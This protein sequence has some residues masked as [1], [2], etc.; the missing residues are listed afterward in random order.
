MQP[1]LFWRPTESGAIQCE[2]CPQ[3]CLIAAGKSGR[4]GIRTAEDG[5]LLARGYGLVSAA[6]SDPMEKKPLYHFHPGRMIFSVGGWG[7]NLACGF[8]QNWTISQQVDLRSERMPP[9][10]IVRAA[11]REKSIGIAYTY[12]EP[13][14]NLE[15]VHDCA[16]LARKEGLVNVLVTNGFVE[17]KPAAWLLPLIDALN[18]DIKSLDDTF[19][20]KQCR[21]TLEPVL[22][23]SRQA[24]A[25]GC[26]VEI[27]NLLIP[28]LNDTEEQVG[29]VSRW[30]LDNLGKTTPFHLSAYRP[31]YRMTIPATPAAVLERS[32]ARCRQDL[33]YVYVGNLLTEDG[34][35]TLCPKCGAVLIARRG[36][37]VQVRG[38]RGGHCAQ[39]GRKADGVGF[40]R[41][42]AK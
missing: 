23:F 25:A 42:S 28:G 10:E 7:C 19:Y 36:Y 15:F 34:Q 26:H 32:Y 11:R 38:L 31:E 33:A 16:E 29:R 12:N 22:R 37:S 14:I 6:R 40:D 9:D 13:L 39:C 35:N 1:A 20:R 2:L 5:K 17:E 4:C 3:H 8:C 18:I 21:G 30:I 27:T 24:V 41:D